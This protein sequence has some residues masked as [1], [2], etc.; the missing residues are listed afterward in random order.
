MIV[1]KV[2]EVIKKVKTKGLT[3]EEAQVLA[4]WYNKNQL[5]KSWSYEIE[6]YEY[7]ITCVPE[8]DN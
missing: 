3:K 1:W 6:K 5:S 8:S 2:M 4:D 7:E